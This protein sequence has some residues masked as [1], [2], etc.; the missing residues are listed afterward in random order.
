VAQVTP[1][2]DQATRIDRYLDYLVGEWEDIPQVSD[3][4][5]EWEDHD[6]LDFVVE[7]PIREDRLH[8]LR[9][10]AAQGLLTPEQQARYDEL[11]QLI[12]CH[13]PLLDRLLNEDE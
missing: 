2:A 1:Q 8:Q 3:E 13:R 12:A 4:W 9:E 7:W 6:R 5:G 10:W 11:L